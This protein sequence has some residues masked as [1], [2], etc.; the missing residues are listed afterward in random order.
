MDVLGE[1][2]PGLNGKVVGFSLHRKGGEAQ[3]KEYEYIHRTIQFGFPGFELQQ[4]QRVR[5][6]QLSR[7]MSHVPE[8]R[9]SQHGLFI[10]VQVLGLRQSIMASRQVNRCPPIFRIIFSA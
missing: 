9:N 10:H 4:L 1:C 3:Q 2:G 8:F 6:M 7:A 5:R